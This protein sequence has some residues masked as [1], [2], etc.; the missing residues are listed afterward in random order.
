MSVVFARAPLRVSLGGGGTDLPSYYSRH[1]GL[2]VSAAIDKYVY[3]LANT[4]F[5]PSFRLKHFEWEDVAEVDDIAH[6]LLREAL[7]RSWNGAPLEITSVG[8]VP[9]GTGLGSSG[10]YTVC[11]LKAITLARG[12]ELTRGEL[13]EAACEVEINR[14]GRKVGKQDQYAAAHGGVNAYRFNQDGSVDVEP[15]AID[16]GT[17]SALCERFL[18]F[19]TGGV[20]SASRMLAE[21]VSRTAAGDVAVEQNLQRTKELAA[22]SRQALEGGDLEHFGGLMNEQFETKRSRSRAAITPEIERLRAIA[23]DAGAQGVMLMG[24]GGGGFLLALAADP[25][26]VRAAFADSGTAELRFALDELGARGEVY[27]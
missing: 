27:A 2:V 20:R 19:F 12:D 4:A 25:A 5:Q 18:A 9:P 3:M 1:G 13:A 26:G 23:L 6:P 8:D 11:V 21:Q 7:R 14:A 15:L 24:A 16:A 10:A 22:E 17:R